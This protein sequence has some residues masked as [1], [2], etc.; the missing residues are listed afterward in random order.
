VE[1][2]NSPCPQSNWDDWIP[3]EYYFS[4]DRARAITDGE[5]RFTAGPLEGGWYEV[6]VLTSGMDGY[7]EGLRV[8]PGQALAGLEIATEPEEVD[9]PADE[10]PEDEPAEEESEEDAAEPKPVLA[11]VRGRVTGP[12]GRPVEAARLQSDYDQTWTDAAGR[13]EAAGRRRRRVPPRRPQTRLRIR[14]G[15]RGPR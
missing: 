7:L 12:E 5:G 14:S 8:E 15:V 3:G 10:D 2:G 6:L 11:L 4:P 9:E 13:F 1:P